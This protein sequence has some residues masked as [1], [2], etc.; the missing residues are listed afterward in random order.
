M[1][2]TEATNGVEAAPAGEEE[3]VVG[4]GRHR[5]E[6]YEKSYI[7][8]DVVTHVAVS[9]AD[10]FITGSADGHLK[11]WKKKPVGIEFAKHFRSHLGPIE[12]LAVSIDGLLCCT[13]SNDRSV[14][15]YDQGEV[16]VKLAISDRDTPTVYIYDARSGT[17]YPVISKEMHLSPVNFMRY[18]HMFDA[19]IS[20]DSKGIIEYWNLT[21]LAFPEDEVKFK[22]KS[23]T[24]L[25]KIV[26]CKTTVS[27]I[28][29]TYSKGVARALA[30]A[31]WPLPV[32]SSTMLALWGLSQLLHCV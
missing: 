2:D 4:P 25:F 5:R 11:F 31:E 6:E 29:S 30:V 12:G 15:I 9:A 28:G 7:H 1:A 17:N 22:L 27:A 18:N 3:A 23:D 10:F 32:V 19:V 14:K 21:T 24:N 26:K 16:K 13:I 8:R 20:S